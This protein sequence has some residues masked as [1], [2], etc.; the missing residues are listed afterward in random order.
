MNK[1]WG[2]VRTWWSYCQSEKGR[3]D[4][5]DYGRAVIVLLAIMLGIYMAARWFFGH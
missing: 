5:L 2:Y 3:H 1:I 4:I